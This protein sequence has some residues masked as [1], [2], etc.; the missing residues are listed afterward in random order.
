MPNELAATGAAP[1]RRAFWLLVLAVAAVGAALRYPGL[2]EQIVIDD[3]WHQLDRAAQSTWWELLT[4]YYPRATSIPNN[5]YL[6]L[7]LDAWGWTEVAIRIPT[8]L[9][10][11]ATFALW[12]WVVARIFG[13]RRL[14]LA[15]T[16]AFAVSGFWIMYGQSSR[17]YAP[18]LLLLIAAYDRFERGVASGRLRH[19][20]QFAVLAALAVPFHLY[21]LPV[22]AG[23][24]VA[25]LGALLVA[26]WRARDGALAATKRLLPMVEGYALWALLVAAFFALPL[27]HDMLHHFPRSVAGG[28]WNGASWRHLGELLTGARYPWLV[29]V[30]LACAT[31]GIASLWRV[32]PFP[33]VLL[34]AGLFAS[35]VFT[36]VVHPK[37]YFAAIVFLRYNVLAHLLFFLGIGRFVELVALG[38]AKLLARRAPGA[39]AL[40]AEAVTYAAVAVGLVLGSPIPRDLAIRPNNFRLHRAYTIAYSDVASTLPW[41]D[42][43]GGV[44]VRH[45][46]R[47][48]PAFYRRLANAKHP[49][50]VIEWPAQY[51]DTH[52]LFYFYQQVHHCTVM[53]GFTPDDD[54]GRELVARVTGPRL[55][56]RRLANI[57]ALAPER[58]PADYLIVHRDL[59]TEENRVNGRPSRRRAERVAPE[60]TEELGLLEA[61]FGAPRFEDE[62]ITVFALRAGLELPALDEP[63]TPS[64]PRRPHRR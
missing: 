47:D 42:G 31:A 56:F 14:A 36:L 59:D 3:E 38:V 52:A 48:F 20:A 51:G 10:T 2:A 54:V 24:G 28:R 43:A 25:G 21:A 26:A 61:K 57:E 7:L 60:I 11:L 62:S 32:R 35:I 46:P 45:A 5:V 18:F 15:S 64:E 9:A 44:R 39:V 8:V 63:R 6:R 19:W 4:N 58:A 53:A 27:L 33:L 22:C 13:S 40:A 49:C 50:R 41:A 12:P 55:R 16:F 34:A 29:V 37:D 23:F 30:L 1:S 17:P